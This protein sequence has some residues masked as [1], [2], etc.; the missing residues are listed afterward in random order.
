MPSSSFPFRNPAPIPTAP[1]SKFDPISTVPTSL[2]SPAGLILDCLSFF[3]SFAILPIALGSMPG[4]T[5]R[6]IRF[7]FGIRFF[8]S[9]DILDKTIYILCIDSGLD[10]GL[11]SFS[12]FDEE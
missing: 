10:S 8:D 2:L 7:L 5:F 3:L 11:E 9:F 1:K 6:A 4:L 12:E